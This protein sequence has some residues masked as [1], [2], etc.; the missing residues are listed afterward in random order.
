LA[1]CLQIGGSPA[2]NL[3]AILGPFRAQ[4]QFSGGRRRG[5]LWGMLAWIVSAAPVLA[6]TVLPFLYWR[7]GLPLTL[8]LG[9]LYSAGLYVCTLGP[10][11]RLLQVREYEVLKAVTHQE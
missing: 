6:L 8:P 7:P 1:V 9:L 10:L 11:A 3:A 2:Y 4:L 5:N